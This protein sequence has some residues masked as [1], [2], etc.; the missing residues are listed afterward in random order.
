MKSITK[1]FLESEITST[2]Y[3][4]GVGT[5]THCYITV[6]SGFVF[7]GESACVDESSFNEEIGQKIAYENAFEK[8]WMCYG[9]W[10]KQKQGSDFLYRLENE[11]AELIEK[12]D[13]LANLLSNA[14]V[15]SKTQYDLLDQQQKHM[16]DYLNVL[17]MR[18]DEIYS[19]TK[20]V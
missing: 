3:K 16:Q 15:L 8:M 4:R 10:L 6:K 11:K 7:T 1:E 5:L 14:N 13:K 2:E 20:E 17:D 12:L 18:L 9:F 19:K